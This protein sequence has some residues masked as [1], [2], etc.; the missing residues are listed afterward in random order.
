[1][2]RP[3]QGST[4]STKFNFTPDRLRK[5]TCPADRARLYLYDAKVAG[6]ALCVTRAGSKIWYWVKWLNSRPERLRLGTFEALSLT[7]VRQKASLLNAEVL[8]GGSPVSRER[9]MGGDT[10]LAAAFA[11]YL[12]FHCKAR[13]KRTWREDERRFKAH[14]TLDVRAR[15]KRGRPTRRGVNWAGRRLSQITRADVQAW[16]AKVAADAPFEANRTCTLLHGVFEHAIDWDYQGANPV[17]IRRTARMKEPSRDRRLEPKELPA[18]FDALDAYPDSKWADLVRLLLFSGVR[19]GQ[20]E[21]AQWEDIDFEE[22][23]WRLKMTKAG[24]PLTIP[25]ADEAVEVLRRRRAA[26]PAD[27]PWVFGSIRQGKHIADP[28]PAWR[29]ICSAAGI[30]TGHG[31]DGKPKPSC[32]RMHDLRRSLATAMEEAGVP[33]NLIRKGLGH[34]TEGVL[35]VYTRAKGEPIRRAVAKGIDWLLR[36][37]GRRLPWQSRELAQEA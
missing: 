20:A 19:R 22:R 9:R 8:G 31:P 15:G 35:G 21:R 26:V 17:R 6:L 1:M 30:P 33:D 3:K 27:V 36:Q 14:F 29:K 37:A 18:F 13:G 32:L 25:L 5:A 11:H 10:T 34:A 12:E 28:T 4:A 16:Y 2:P 23:T 24:T 7:A